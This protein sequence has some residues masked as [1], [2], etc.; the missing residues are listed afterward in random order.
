MAKKATS[1]FDRFTKASTVSKQRIIAASFG[2][3]GMLKTSFWLTAPGPIVIQ[4]T[5]QGLEGVVD[6]YLQNLL[7]ETGQ[8]KDIYVVEY[9]PMVGVMAQ[10][11]AVEIRNKFIEDFEHALTVAKTVVW[12]KE[13]GVYEIFKYAEFGAPSDT[14]SNYYSL[15]QRYRHVV[16]LAKGSDV[17]F[18]LIQG[19]RDAWAP[20]VNK[21]TGAQGAAKTEERIRRG[22]REIEELV[23]IN[24]HHDREDDRFV[25][26]VGKS[27]GPGGRDCQNSTIDYCDFQTFAQ[28]IFP[29]SS[30]EDWV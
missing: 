12:D 18:G 6:V 1:D 28:L 29:T 26:K 9:D 13:T 22:M 5:D 27:R 20:K 17:N 14:P 30:P 21:K 8:T 7:A 25:L 2:E 3:V 15:D 19:M 11:E 24:L 4:S 16:N 10:E 23:H